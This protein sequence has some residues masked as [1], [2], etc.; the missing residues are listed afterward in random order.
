MSRARPAIVVSTGRSGST[1][2]SNMLREHPDVLSLSEFFVML[3][4]DAFP[5]AAVSGPRFWEILSRPAESLRRLQRSQLTF[6]EVLYRPGPGRRFTYEAGIPP[7]VLTTLPH[8]TRDPEE[9]FDELAEWVPGVDE[10]PIG[11]QYRR[12][13]DW[14]CRRFGRRVWVERSG[15]SLPMVRVLARLFPDA[16]FVHLHRD[17]RE[18]AVSMSLHDGFKLLALRQH[19]ELSPPDLV[20]GDRISRDALA[21]AQIPPEVL[22]GIWSDMTLAGAAELAQLEPGRV[23]LLA[24]EALMNDPAAELRRLT[25]FI[26]VEADPGWL[27]RASSLVQPRSPRWTALPGPE[28]RRLT[29]ACAPGMDLLRSAG[30]SV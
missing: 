13:F 8:L 16:G 26:G 10:R 2:V 24:Y 3:R 15:V 20:D 9:L 28:R 12:L 14:L 6:D 25:A 5:E 7:V 4:E 29:E 21:R 23:A 19:P 17:G 11:D 22:G 30:A 18:C 27:E 1:L